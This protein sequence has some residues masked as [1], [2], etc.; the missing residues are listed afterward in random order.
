[1]LQV[2]SQVYCVRLARAIVLARSEED[3]GGASILLLLTVTSPT[4]P[5]DC[6]PPCCERARSWTNKTTHHELLSATSHT[7]A[8]VLVLSACAARCR[9]RLVVVVVHVDIST[10]RAP[11]VRQAQ[12][13]LFLPI[14]KDHMLRQPSVANRIN[15]KLERFAIWYIWRVSRAGKSGHNT[16]VV[17]GSLRPCHLANAAEDGVPISVVLCV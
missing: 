17:I 4:P 13:T 2:D 7:E 15:G 11:Q 5:T 9:P 6:R 12:E 16:R 14:E 3:V 1:M 10:T 8:S